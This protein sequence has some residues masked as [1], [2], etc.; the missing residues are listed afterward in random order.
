MT[1]RPLGRA[2]ASAMVRRCKQQS[3]K[4]GGDP[5]A[6]IVRDLAVGGNDLDS[7]DAVRA[8]PPQADARSWHRLVC[9]LS[10]AS[11]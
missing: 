7:D 6:E 2:A 4:D 1:S 9:N 11:A 3:A 10:A 5:S 8:V